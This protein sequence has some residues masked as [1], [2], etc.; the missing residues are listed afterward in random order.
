KSDVAVRDFHLRVFRVELER[1]TCLAIRREI[2]PL[3]KAVLGI[4]LVAVIAI[5]LLAVHLR[6]IAREM[7][8]MVE[9]ERVGI[10]RLLAHELKFRMLAIEGSKDLR[11]TARR[12]RHFPNHLLRRMRAKME[13]GGRKLRPL[14]RGRFHHVAI[15][16]TRSALRIRDPFHPGGAEMFLVADGAGAVLDH[17]RLVRIV[18]L[19]LLLEARIF[20][21]AFLAPQI[22]R[23]EIDAAM[24][25]VVH[26]GLEFCEG[27]S[28]AERGALIV[29][30]GAVR[31]VLGVVAG[32]F[33]RVEKLLTRALTKNHLL[34]DEDAGDAP[35]EREKADAEPRHPPRMLPLVIAKIAFVTFGDLL[36]GPCWRSHD[37]RSVIKKCHGGVPHREEQKKK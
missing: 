5:E 17:V 36:L 15:V 4:G 20:L 30:D 24:E 11:V 26:Y 6:N 22:D 16:M 29:A 19:F 35:G 21:V 34:I 25:P 3:I 7:A 23:G 33:S 18:F 14:L 28:L 27:D 31:R 12:S 1:M 9:P 2:D 37:A 8:L 32:D 13:N 10:A